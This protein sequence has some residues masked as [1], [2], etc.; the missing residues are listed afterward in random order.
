[1]TAQTNRWL[2]PFLVAVVLAGGCGGVV[3]PSQNKIDPFSGSLEPGGTKGHDF[4]VEKNG[5]ID[6]KLTALSNPDAIVQLA[7]GTGAC[8]SLSLLNSGYRQV[9]QVGVGGLVSKGDHC[10]VIADSL[11]HLRQ[12]AT[13]TIT[14]SHP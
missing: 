3:D 2:T 11:G 1:M 14:V 7:Y 5:E 10:V 13:Y 6:V 9:N 8:T 4:R 12:P